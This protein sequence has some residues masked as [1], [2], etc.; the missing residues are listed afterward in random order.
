V[1][2]WRR[3]STRGT[4]GTEDGQDSPGV[5]PRHDGPADPGGYSVGP[6]VG[7]ELR[8][9]AAAVPEDLVVAE[10][11]LIDT[12]AL[13][14]SGGLMP[15][16]FVEGGRRLGWSGPADDQ[17]GA[18]PA[19]SG[20]ADTGPADTGPADTGGGSFVSGIFQAGPLAVGG[21]V[22][23]GLNI[24]ATVLIARLLTPRQYGGVAQLLGLFFVL[25]MPGSALLVGVVR[26]IAAGTA[27]GRQEHVHRWTARLGRRCL[28]GLV[29]WVAISVAVEE[30]LA[31]ALRLPS[32]GGVAAVLI[33]GGVWLLLCIDRAV[34]QGH[35]RYAGL[36][37]NLIVEIGIRTVFVLSFAAAGFGI[38]GYGIGL[39]LGE[40][41]ATVHARLLSGR[42]W[43]YPAAPSLAPDLVA[44]DR[45][46]T[47]DLTVA[48]VGFVLL[49]ILQNADIILVG[50]LDPS[51]AGP[52][53]AISVASK[54]L[55]FGA[56]LLGSYVLPE[57]A[58]RWHQGQHALRQL[59]VTLI[60]LMVPSL[61]LLAVALVA[62]EQFLT[63]FFSAR[64]NG[65]AP[66]FATLVGAM[67]CLG[68]VVVMTNYLFGAAR[69]WIVVLLAVGVVVLVILIHG[70]HGA[71]VPT[72]RAE[73]AVQGG[74]A[75][76][77]AVAFA[78]VHLRWWHGSSS[79]V[80][81]TGPDD[82]ITSI[83]RR[84]LGGPV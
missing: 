82:G 21:L 47:I 37:L 34:L 40:V 61:V 81:S 33:A 24:V 59:A 83:G 73:L 52:Y 56:I 51:S 46:L 35:R 39:L 53:A 26:R 72:A 49:G 7:P 76:A 23:N 25:S 41:V 18:L 64:L 50:R 74:L 68:L 67:A 69:R 13:T 55:V 43:N 54:S 2:A 57:A 31:S 78:V 4:R 36:G 11:S 19:E 16:P 66:A 12:V 5:E 38:A 8:T 75:L 6:S 30:P 44:K 15:D 9:A 62:P 80:A 14:P 3:H 71:I 65:A 1:T 29:V 17:T 48:F 45:T 27:Q 42:A 79:P 60:F 10:E 70:A 32:S 77:V 63:T 84:D 58:L 28:V 22:A 20:P